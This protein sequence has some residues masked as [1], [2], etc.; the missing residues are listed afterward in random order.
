MKWVV[1]DICIKPGMFVLSG[2]LSKALPFRNG[3][4]FEADF[5]VLGKV[6]VIISKRSGDKMNKVKVGIIGSGNIGTDLMYKIERMPSIRN[7]CYGRD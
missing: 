1:Y 4:H 5:G 6:S 7:E 2:A 3:D